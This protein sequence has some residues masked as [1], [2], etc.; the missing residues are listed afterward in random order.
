[1]YTTVS[2]PPNISLIKSSSHALEIFRIFIKYLNS[3]N[4]IISLILLQTTLQVY[5]CLLLNRI[6]YKRNNR[7]NYERYIERI[8]VIMYK[9][10]SAQSWKMKDMSLVSDLFLLHSE[11]QKINIYIYMYRHVYINNKFL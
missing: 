6:P 7:G 10:L 5:I 9:R 4:I 8:R 3:I 2:L 1:L 11:K